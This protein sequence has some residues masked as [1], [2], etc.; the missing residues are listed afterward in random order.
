VIFVGFVTVV[1]CP[2]LTAQPA[3]S[4]EATLKKVQANVASFEAQLPD[5]VADEKIVSR[6]LVSKRVTREVT[7]DSVFTAVQKK[8]RMFS[9]TESREV[10][11]RNGHAAETEEA[12]HGPFLFTGGFSSILHSTFAA[13]NGQF[14][15]YRLKGTQTIDKRK[16]VL[17]EFATIPD[18]ASLKL[19]WLGKTFYETASG[20]AWVDPVT[21]E[22]IR[23]ERVYRDLPSPAVS[24][25]VMVDYKPVPIDGRM[26]NMPRR[27][28]AEELTDKSKKRTRGVFVAEYANYRRFQVSSGVR[29]Q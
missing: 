26:F 15:T 12:L 21:L 3:R 24:L 14:H 22:V 11:K 27:V 9:F 5:F 4:L 1:I 17:I 6:N 7:Y 29:F 20:R 28:A 13:Q 2:L 10:R 16:T 18:Q 19:D 8:N 25:T 23:L